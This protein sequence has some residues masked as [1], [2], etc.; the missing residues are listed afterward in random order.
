M[1]KRTTWTVLLLALAASGYAQELTPAQV[2]AD[3]ARTAAAVAAAT[4]QPGTNRTAHHAAAAQQA[5]I[6]APVAVALAEPK[7]KERAAGALALTPMDT[8]ADPVGVQAQVQPVQSGDSYVQQVV[9]ASGAVTNEMFNIGAFDNGITWWT[10]D[11]TNNGGSSTWPWWIKQPRAFAPTNG[12]VAVSWG[13]TNAGIPDGRSQINCTIPYQTNAWGDRVDYILQF[14]Y[15]FTNTTVGTSA[16]FRCATNLTGTNNIVI[17]NSPQTTNWTQVTEPLL[18]ES[19]AYPKLYWVLANSGKAALDAVQFVP[20]P[21]PAPADFGLGAS[22]TG[23]GTVAVVQWQTLPFRRWHL[24]YADDLHGPWAT[25]TAV[26]AVADFVATATFTNAG[27]TIRFYRM[28]H[29]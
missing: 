4:V 28:A 23:G 11:P 25:N 10:D 14:K 9:A 26:P 22:G 8:Q 13:F 21:P 3:A 7:L 20:V 2:A 24:E 15:T 19:G 12:W 29:N 6:A 17:L 16:F 1:K 27:P 18:V 5:A